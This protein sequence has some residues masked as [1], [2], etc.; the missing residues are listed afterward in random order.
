MVVLGPGVPYVSF[1]FR[2]V[3]TVLSNVDTPP[4]PFGYS[5]PSSLSPFHS[6]VECLYITLIAWSKARYRNQRPLFPPRSVRVPA[7]SSLTLVATSFR[8]CAFSIFRERCLNLHAFS[9]IWKRSFGFD[10]SYFDPPYSNSY[11][12]H[13]SGP[14]DSMRRSKGIILTTRMPLK[15]PRTT[16]K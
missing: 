15:H 11:V 6:L 9:N 7:A 4:S 13:Q 12:D 10:L 1:P 3:P 2:L 8:F 5:V 14:W 16:P